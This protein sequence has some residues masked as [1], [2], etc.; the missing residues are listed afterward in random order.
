MRERR[1]RLFLLL[2]LLL[3][4]DKSLL[5]D[6]SFRLDVVD[7]DGMPGDVDKE[8]ENFP[9]QLGDFDDEAALFPS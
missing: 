5:P 9:F 2:L 8:D 6:P 4:L 3:L 7:W 1:G